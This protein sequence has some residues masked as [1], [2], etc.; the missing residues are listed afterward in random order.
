[1][2]RPQYETEADRVREA[3]AVKKF[4]DRYLDTTA[5]KLEYGASADY[6]VINEGR[7]VAYIEVKTRTCTSYQYK[8]YHISKA[9][10]IALTRLGERDGLRPL[11]LVQWK[12]KTGVISV[13]KFLDN[14]TYTRGGRYDRNDSFDIEE[15]AEVDISLFTIL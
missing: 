14:A 2:P 8:T 9:K 10:L 3:K 11:L 5:E 7:P 12:D 1:M 4:T 15:M 6:R 13:K